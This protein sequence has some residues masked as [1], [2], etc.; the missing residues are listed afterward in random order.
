[1]KKL[2]TLSLKTSEIIFILSVLSRVKTD[3]D[4]IAYSI[5]ETMKKLGRPLRTDN[6][7]VYLT[8]LKFYIN[9]NKLT[10]LTPTGKWKKK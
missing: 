3:N 5:I 6:R 2:T 8:Y 7:K 1:M 10:Q 9:L 4:S